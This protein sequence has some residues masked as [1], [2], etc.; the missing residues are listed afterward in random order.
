[1]EALAIRFAQENFGDAEL[2]DQRLTKRLVRAALRMLEHPEGTLP[3]KMQTPADLKGLY[4]L[5]DHDQVT[6]AAVLQTHRELTLSRMAESEEVVLLIHDT[7]QLNYTSRKSLEGLG[8]LAAGGG[9]GYLAHNTLAVKEDGSVIGLANQI[10]YLRPKVPKKEP[11]E[12]RRQR[13]NRET[14]L[15]KAG[16]EAVGPPRRRASGWT[17]ATGAGTCSSTWTTSMS[18]TAITSC[19]PSTTASCGPGTTRTAW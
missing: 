6:H 8:Q 19:G 17:C 14:R 3:A 7:T 15:W 9:K 16:S 1:M 18:R 4:R 12:K 5:V 2:G 10:L 11:R 13:R